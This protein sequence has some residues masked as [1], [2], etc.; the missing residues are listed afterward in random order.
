MS[1]VAPAAAAPAAAKPKAAKKPAK[2]PEHPAYKVMVATAVIDK[3]KK[4]HGPTVDICKTKY[5]KLKC[6]S[7][8][9]HL[10]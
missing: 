4:C 7:L 3:Y 5:L 2:V 9:L 1:N 10:L 8:S 6:V